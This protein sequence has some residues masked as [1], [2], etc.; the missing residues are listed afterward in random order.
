MDK[1]FQAVGTACTKALRWDCAKHV[2][3]T[4]RRPGWLR[5]SDGRHSL[6][7]GGGDVTDWWGFVEH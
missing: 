5:R 4:A 1:E 2:G 6:D 7:G 3:A